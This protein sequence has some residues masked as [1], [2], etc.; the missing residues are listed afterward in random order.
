MIVFGIHHFRRPR[1]MLAY[2]FSCLPGGLLRAY[3][4]GVVFTPAGLVLI[5]NKW[6]SVARLPPHWPFSKF[7]FAR[8]RP[9]IPKRRR[10]SN[11]P[12]CICKF[13][14]R[15]GPGS[16]CNVRGSQ[17]KNQHLNTGEGGLHSVIK[18]QQMSNKYNCLFSLPLELSQ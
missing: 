7:R 6:V 18:L 11:A 13:I 3:L 15:P 8:T 9:T 10:C 14:E 1:N 5:F 16:L 12:A 17:W 2:V 4:V